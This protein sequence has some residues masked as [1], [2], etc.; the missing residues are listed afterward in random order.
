MAFNRATTISYTCRYDASDQTRSFTWNKQGSAP[1]ASL[2]YAP[3]NE[4]MVDPP[5]SEGHDVQRDL[6]CECHASDES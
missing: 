5:G 3:D 6:R 2:T 4:S 1:M